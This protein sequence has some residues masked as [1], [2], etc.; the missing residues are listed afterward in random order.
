M[1]PLT[2]IPSYHLFGAHVGLRNNAR[3]DVSL[4]VRNAFNQNYYNTAAVSAQYGVVLAALGEPRT[5]GATLRAT[6]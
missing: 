1:D 6:F 5:F 2:K 3:W 4:W